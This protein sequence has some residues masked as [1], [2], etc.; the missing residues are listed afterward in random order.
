M[1][2][3]D[4]LKDKIRSEVVSARNRV[5]AMQAEAAEQY[6][7]AQVRYKTF[8][9][10]S[11]RIRDAVRPHLEAFAEALPDVTP[12][13]SRRDFGPGGR[14]FH[15]VFVSFAIP[16]SERCPATLDLRFGLEAGPGVE[17]LILSYDLE[18]IPVFM[19]FERR[20]R[21]ALPLDPS[22]I[23]KAVEWF[24]QKAVTFTKTYI[25]MLFNPHYHGGSDVSD[26]V[27]G[28][29]FPRVF[30]KGRTEHQGRTYYFF[31]EDSLKAFE[32]DP[33]RYVGAA[34]GP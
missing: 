20:D 17:N 32:A 24:D 30:A 27:L 19:E 6:E 14:G 5:H 10:L 31:T 21:I 16:R 4:A 9:D 25:N 11:Q 3:I 15:G 2:D 23:A 7:Q 12:T 29:S 34:Q 8:L 28:M 33:T 1:T 26:V 13:V 22:S 18:I